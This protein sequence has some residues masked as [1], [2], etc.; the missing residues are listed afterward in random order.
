MLLLLYSKAVTSIFDPT[1][2]FYEIFVGIV[3]MAM[4]YFR[5]ERGKN[6]F[7]TEWQKIKRKMKK[8]SPKVPTFGFCQKFPD[9][10]HPP[11]L[12]RV[13]TKSTAPPG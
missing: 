6:I 11:M 12:I 10:T 3:L 5:A 4:N 13:R 8:L 2:S 1:I 7:C 9:G